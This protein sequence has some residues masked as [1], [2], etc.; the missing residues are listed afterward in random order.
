[1]ADLPWM[2]GRIRVSFRL[3]S[4]RYFHWKKGQKW[5]KQ[6][7]YGRGMFRKAGW[8]PK[9]IRLILGN[10][11]KQ[12]FESWGYALITN[13]IQSKQ[14]QP[15]PKGWDWRRLELRNSRGDAVMTWARAGAG[16]KEWTLRWGVGIREY[17]EQD[18]IFILCMYVSV[19]LLCIFF[20]VQHMEV[21]RPGIK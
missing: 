14:F 16:S 19:Y 13:L 6:N 3:G 18:S 9:M 11:R 12:D 7:S 17:Q 15:F 2:L 20:L 8:D 21:P 4:E 1:M 5:K 10:Q